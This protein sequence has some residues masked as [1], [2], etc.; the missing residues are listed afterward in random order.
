MSFDLNKILESK[1]ALRRTLAAKPLVE[2]LRML[3]ALR[4]REIAIRGSTTQSDS[5]SVREKPAADGKRSA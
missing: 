5:E 1:R 2:K 3:D 4:G